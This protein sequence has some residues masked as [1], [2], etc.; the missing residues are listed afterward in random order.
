MFAYNH[1]GN[2][3]S[4][5][6]LVLANSQLIKF[7]ELCHTWLPRVMDGTLAGKT[8]VILYEF[9]VGE[10]MPNARKVQFVLAVIGLSTGFALAEYDS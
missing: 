7:R 5:S 8:I 9:C 1:H 6:V 3:D 4:N 10:K 2:Q